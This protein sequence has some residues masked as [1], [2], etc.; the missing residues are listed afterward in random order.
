MWKLVLGWVSGFKSDLT[1]EQVCSIGISQLLWFCLFMASRMVSQATSCDRCV[2]DARQERLT[3]CSEKPTSLIRAVSRF[4]CFR[5]YSLRILLWFCTDIP[6][7]LLISR[8]VSSTVS[9]KR[10]QDTLLLFQSGVIHRCGT[11]AC[12]RTFLFS[13][14]RGQL[15]VSE[16]LETRQETAVK[17]RMLEMH[18]IYVSHFK[19]YQKVCQC[20]KCFTALAQF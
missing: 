10:L 20:V 15:F 5:S 2:S 19:L 14:C 18:T 8:C 1:W 13:C 4:S 12:V 6:V 7:R 9:L 3:T 11:L 17:N 16:H